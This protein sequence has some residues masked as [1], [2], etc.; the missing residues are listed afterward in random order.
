MAGMSVAASS[1]PGYSNA[2]LLSGVE[3]R[4]S[5][6]EFGGTSGFQ[7]YYDGNPYADAASANAAAGAARDAAAKSVQGTNVN[8][9]TGSVVNTGG[10]MPSSYSGLVSATGGSTA[11]PAGGG[12]GGGVYVPNPDGSG[13]MLTQAGYE[14]ERS[15]T[16]AQGSQSAQQAAQIKAASEAAAA[17]DAAHRGDMELAARLQAQAEQTRMGFVSQVAG[18]TAPHVGATSGPA[19]DETA[20]RAAAF[21]RAKDQ[22]GMT[23][24]A[25]LEG[26]RAATTSRGV[27]GS[28][29]EG[30][31]LARIIGGGAGEVNRYTTDQLMSDLNRTAD[32]S[33]RNYQGDITQ[34]GQDMSQ[35]ASLLGLITASGGVGAY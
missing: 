27:N 17:A 24:N 18:N 15:Q 25:A 11:G 32:I 6:N 23:A 10:P 14:N 3:Q 35:L 8:S 21:A 9:G 34:R 29:I 26:L 4:Q 31:G 19:P 1:L 33:D 2:P 13:P 28:T 7:Y 30:E 16:S 5:H 12:G 20:A 22:A